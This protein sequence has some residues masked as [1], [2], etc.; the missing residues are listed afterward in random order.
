MGCE[1][2]KF[3]THVAMT[4]TWTHVGPVSCDF[5]EGSRKACLGT[6]FGTA[7]TNRRHVY[8]FQENLMGT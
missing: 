3:E 7:R 8:M 6:D 2:D 1:R 4:M 5:H